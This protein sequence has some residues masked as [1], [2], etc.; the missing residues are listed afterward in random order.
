M[1]KLIPIATDVLLGGILLVAA[2]G[3]LFPSWSLLGLG[4]VV[5]LSELLFA[6]WLFS[7]WRLAE[8]A[9]VAL[10][11]HVGF[12]VL[13]VQALRGGRLSQHSR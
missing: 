12:V 3:K 1:R 9:R 4:V 10:L 8:A 6:A 5:S 7:G 2:I 13:A 11:F